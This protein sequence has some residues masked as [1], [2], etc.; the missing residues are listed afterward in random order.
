MANDMAGNKRRTRRKEKTK[1]IRMKV[2]DDY[3]DH[4]TLTRGNDP[5]KFR[6]FL[7]ANS[8]LF[9]LILP[10]PRSVR[11]CLPGLT[12]IICDKNFSY[13]GADPRSFLCN[14]RRRAGSRRRSQKCRAISRR[15]LRIQCIPM[16]FSWAKE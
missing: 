16:R 11:V 12:N 8:S 10:L 14:C 4:F 3:I 2:S 9:S 5:P 1:S 15:I 13:F 7:S 6:S